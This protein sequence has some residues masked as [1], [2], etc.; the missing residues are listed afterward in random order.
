MNKSPDEVCS[1]LLNYI[2]TLPHTITKLLLFSDRAA[3]Q[4]KN[5]TVVRL[6][7]YLC[8]IGR[9]DMIRLYFPVRGHS[10]PCDR[11]FGSIKRLIRNAD[12]IYTTEQYGELFLRA[13]HNGQFNIHYVKTEEMLAFKDW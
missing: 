6:L 1:F 4:N 13:S 11:D 9:F 12:R 10:F 3:G 2:N 7:M 8:D 5:H